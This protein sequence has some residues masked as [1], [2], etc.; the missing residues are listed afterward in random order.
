[1]EVGG[2]RGCRGCRGLAAKIFNTTFCFFCHLME[3]LVSLLPSKVSKINW[4]KLQT[5]Y[6]TLCYSQIKYVF[7]WSKQHKQN[8]KV[9][10]QGCILIFFFLEMFLPLQSLLLQKRF[11]QLFCLFVYPNF[12]FCFVFQ[13]ASSEMNSRISVRNRRLIL[14]NNNVLHLWLKNDIFYSFFI[15]EMC[16]SMFGLGIKL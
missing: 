9:S 7:T 10:S 11:C 5:I 2:C 3:F 1:M 12:L 13:I 15:E 8:P 16:K 6:I 14:S 4:G